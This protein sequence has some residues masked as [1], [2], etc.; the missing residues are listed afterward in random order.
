MVIAAVV[1]VLA[2]TLDVPILRAASSSRNSPRLLT[3]RVVSLRSVIQTPG[4]GCLGRRLNIAPLEDIVA[5]R[6]VMISA[7]TVRCDLTT[8]ASRVAPPPPPPLPRRDAVT[9]TRESSPERLASITITS[10]AEVTTMITA[11][12]M[13]A[14]YGEV[15][16]AT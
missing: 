9:A 16:A 3:R 15:R 4:D 6:V 5:R 11:V 1:L 12:A 7:V 13:A 8:S 10:E 2:C 14:F